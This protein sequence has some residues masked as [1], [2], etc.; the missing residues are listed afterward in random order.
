MLIAILQTPSSERT[1][2]FL[3]ENVMNKDKK[4]PK[5]DKGL[6]STAAITSEREAFCNELIELVK[7]RSTELVRLGFSP[8][9]ANFDCVQTVKMLFDD[10]FDQCSISNAGKEWYRDHSRLMGKGKAGV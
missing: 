3:F 7:M 8:E 6:D 1:T 2:A 4:T 5:G 10:L 9:V